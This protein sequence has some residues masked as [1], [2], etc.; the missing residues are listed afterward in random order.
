MHILIIDDEKKI[1]NSLERLMR[2]LPLHSLRVFKAY[3]AFEAMEILKTEK[4]HIVLS[5]IKMPGMSGIELQREIIRRWPLCK[6]I[7]LTGYGD[8]EYI[9]EA[10]RNGAVDFLM[11][12]EDNETILASVMKAVDAITMNDRKEAIIRK[13][14]QDLRRALPILQ[15]ELIGGLLHKRIRVS[16]LT[17]ARFDELQIPFV[18]EEPVIACYGKVDEWQEAYSAEDK[19]LFSFAIHNIAE[20]ILG[21]G[22]RFFS[23]SEEAGKWLWILQPRPDIRESFLSEQAQPA[24]EAI[25]ETCKEMLKIKLS[26]VIALEWV[27][28]EQLSAKAEHLRAVLH[29]G[30]GI[31]EN[32]LIELP[33]DTE[34]DMNEQ[35]EEL[36]QCLR[37]MTI[38]STYLEEGQREPFYEFYDQLRSHI[39]VLPT[40]LGRY[41]IEVYYSIGLIFVSYLNKFNLWASIEEE[42]DLTRLYTIGFSGTDKEILDYFRE[43]AETIFKANDTR[44]KERSNII[45]EQVNSYI[46]RNLA[47]DLS[48]NI[49]GH[50][51]GY[52]PSYLSRVYKHLTG[53]GIAEYILNQRLTLARSLLKETNLKVYE[54]AARSGFISEGHFFR[55]FKKMTGMTPT[56]YRN[57]H[58]R[59]LV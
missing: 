19:H 23:Y 54:I 4:I 14:Q 47:N 56:E 42:I 53:I 50:A 29:G 22:V 5:D 33:A 3:S 51:I 39:L 37:R 45:V 21:P 36:L 8:F 30:F 17:Q 6:V 15:K 48:L 10:M 28:W 41:K 20:E 11:K 35:E 1:V 13:G 44:Q 18:L 25:Q 43:L 12:T 46:N 40:H 7:F 49:I 38:L 26:L 55:I 2:R 16:S 24:L 59:E 52:N 34:S 57:H 9:K 27:K 58:L 32:L 31:D